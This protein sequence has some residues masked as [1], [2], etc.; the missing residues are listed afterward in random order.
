MCLITMTKRVFCFQNYFD[1]L[2]QPRI[3]KV[4]LDHQNNFFS[5]QVRTILVTKYRIFVTHLL[6]F[7]FHAFPSAGPMTK[8]QKF[9]GAHNQT[10][11][12]ATD[13]VTL[14]TT[15]RAWK[16]NTTELGSYLT[17]CHYF[18][19]TKKPSMVLTKLVESISL[20]QTAKSDDFNHSKWLA[21][22]HHN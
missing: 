15:F 12:I 11:C 8:M 16:N 5:Q 10:M 19:E 9:F 7:P 20:A 22:S 4:F 3:S 21:G 6:A 18:Q 1:L 17:V 14:F 2:F 13:I